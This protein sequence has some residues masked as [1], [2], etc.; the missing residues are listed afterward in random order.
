MMTDDRVDVRLREAGERW[1]ATQPAPADP[2]P[3]RLAAEGRTRRMAPL[4]V[5]AGLVAVLAGAAIVATTMSGHDP[6]LVG[7]SSTAANDAERLLVRD[8]D[9][10]QASGKVI[11]SPTGAA[12]LCLERIS[13]PLGRTADQPEPCTRPIDLRGTIDPTRLGA[14]QLD[15]EISGPAT[16]RGVWTDWVLTVTEQLPPV[17]PSS[18][19][20]PGSE[21]PPCSPPPGGWRPGNAPSPGLDKGYLEQHAERF[22]AVR[23]V[24]VDGAEVYVVEVVSGDLEAARGELA[25]IFAGNLCMT[26][27]RYSNADWRRIAD[28]LMG[29]RRLGVESV[30]GPRGDRKATISMVV[31][32]ERLHAELAKIGFDGLELD[33]AVVPLGR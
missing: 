1:R 28:A 11:I 30:A 13:D 18:S 16:L 10:V 26:R 2:D 8:G 15:G 14:R 27:G 12:R 33:P 5:A 21:P 23:V 32:D 29:D 20:V 9:T 31:L 6:P 24:M 19:P 17:P 7:S 22:G 3:T 4:A 25:R